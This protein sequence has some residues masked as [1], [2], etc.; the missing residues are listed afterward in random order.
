M[1]YIPVAMLLG[2]QSVLNALAFKVEVALMVTGA[3]YGVDPSV[4]SS[5]FVV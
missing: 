5:P 3:V 1:V 2:S 4:G